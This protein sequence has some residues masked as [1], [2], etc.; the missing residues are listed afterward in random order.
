LIGVPRHVSGQGALTERGRLSTDDLLIK[1]A[2]LE[3]KRKIY[4][5]NIESS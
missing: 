2:C 5:F 4:I 1:I 3:K